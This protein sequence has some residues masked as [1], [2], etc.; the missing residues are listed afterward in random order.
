[1]ET[2]QKGPIFI[3]AIVFIN[4][5]DLLW[6]YQSILS[7]VDK[8]HKICIYHCPKLSYLGLKVDWNLLKISTNIETTPKF[9]TVKCKTKR[10]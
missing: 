6:T 8:N 2:E 4:Y 3:Y 10:I 9:H 1:M 7:K 5:H